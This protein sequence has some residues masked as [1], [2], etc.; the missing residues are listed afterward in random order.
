MERNKRVVT[1]IPARGGSKG[2]I[3]KNIIDFCGKPLLVWSIERA[4]NA[5]RNDDVYV[6][7]DDN[8]IAQ[9][10]AQ[11]GAKVIRRPDELA[12][13]TARSED[14]VIHAIKEIE[15][16][17][18]IKAVVFLQA[19]SPIRRENDIDNA[20]EKFKAD[21]LDSLFSVAVLEDYCIWKQTAGVLTSVTFD[22]K[23]RGRRQDR[24]PYFLENGSI[25]LFKPW[26]IRELRNRIGGK[27]GMYE[28][29]FE[30]SYEIDSSEDIPVCEFFMMKMLKECGLREKS[31]L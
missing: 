21:N 13:D 20:I 19:T 22:Y 18:P 2:I 16:E 10:A 7:T 3:D 17:G 26:V 8:R 9:V 30:H 27:V 11:F 29:P 24:E 6:S 12:T 5:T 28:M 1:I 25:Y 4:V 23:N 15:K 31:V 14:A